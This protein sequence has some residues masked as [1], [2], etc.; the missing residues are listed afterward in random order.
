[1]TNKIE[2]LDQEEK[3]LEKA[4]DS[5]DLLKIP[6]PDTMTQ[7]NFKIAAA[8]FK[9]P[10]NKMKTITAKELEEKF[11][12][13]EGISDYM[14]FSNVK[15]LSSCLLNQQSSVKNQKY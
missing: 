12:N 15:K 2:R 10:L 14:D 4:L 6:K 9:K 8:N 13:N 1:M 11:N 3:D 5:I 7:K